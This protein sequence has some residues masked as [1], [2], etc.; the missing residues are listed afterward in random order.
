[1]ELE[2]C[3]VL[4]PD[5]SEVPA[6]ER[7]YF[8]FTEPLGQR[9]DGSISSAE[10]QVNVLIDQVCSSGEIEDVMPRRYRDPFDQVI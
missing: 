2:R 4:R 1:M 7:R 9:H 3:D 5:N 10:T 6:V 8:R